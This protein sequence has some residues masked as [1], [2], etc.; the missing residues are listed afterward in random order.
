MVVSSQLQLNDQIDRLGND[1]SVLISEDG[2][3]VI[4]IYSGPLTPG[5][6]GVV[7][8]VLNAASDSIS[9]R[10]LPCILRI[11]QRCT[12][13][14]L[15]SLDR[16]IHELA[17]SLLQTRLEDLP[18]EIW[19]KIIAQGKLERRD[20]YNVR[21]LS[22][23]MYHRVHPVYASPFMQ[24][25]FSSQEAIDEV[26]FVWKLYFNDVKSAVYGDLEA[27]EKMMEMVVYDRIQWKEK[28]LAYLIQG[29]QRELKQPYAQLQLAIACGGIATSWMEDDWRRRLMLIFP[30]HLMKV[31]DPSQYPQIFERDPILSDVSKEH[32]L[33]IAKLCPNLEAVNLSGARHLNDETLNDFVTQTPALKRILLNDTA[34]TRKGLEEMQQKRPDIQFCETEAEFLGVLEGDLELSQQACIGYHIDLDNQKHDEDLSKEEFL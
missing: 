30:W 13:S 34:V 2:V 14:I 28:F 26:G 21:G 4:S 29:F 32:L 10:H 20:V 18:P 7:L 22:F 3:P 12:P 17:V 25:Y 8:R 16:K 33:Y 19:L 23:D 31:L 27:I 24:D 15:V 5:N 1:L 9:R 11:R 6:Q